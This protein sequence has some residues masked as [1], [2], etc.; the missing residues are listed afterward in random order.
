[1]RGTGNE[2]GV[3]DSEVNVTRFLLLIYAIIIS[4]CEA[5]NAAKNQEKRDLRIYT[6]TRKNIVSGQSDYPEHN[7]QTKIAQLLHQL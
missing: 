2:S 3:G 1:V 6:A 5:I 7:E 4:D